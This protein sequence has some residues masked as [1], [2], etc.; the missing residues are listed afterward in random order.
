MALIPLDVKRAINSQLPKEIGKQI[1]SI[2]IKEFEKIKNSMLQEF[3]SHP[4]TQ[5]IEAG[6]NSSNTSGTL[7][8]YGNLFTFIGFSEGDRPISEVRERLKETSIRKIGYKNGVFDFITT[9]P[10]KEELFA[11]TPMPWASGRSWMDGIETGLS[12]LGLYLYKSGEDIKG[13]RSGPAIQL[14][15]GKK[16]SSA[17]GKGTTGGA[18]KNQ[19][20]RYQRKS[21]ISSILRNFHKSV[22]RLRSTKIA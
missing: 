21:Y 11:M 22:D 18:I 4:V 10:T 6:P 19:R 16:A 9:E 17:F 1:E 20:S 7:G 12:G 3:D 8:G 5:E 2:V 13:S 14:K 15:G